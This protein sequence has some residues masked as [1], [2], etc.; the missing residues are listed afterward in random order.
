MVSNPPEDSPRIRAH[1]IYDDPGAAIE[2]LTR[3]FGLRER[4]KKTSAEGNVE[5]AQLEV[6]DSLITI[7]RPS[8][9]GMS[10]RRGVSSMLYIYI[11]DVDQHFARAKAAGAKIV[12]PLDDRPWGDRNYQAEDPEGHQW[13]FAQRVRDGALDESWSKPGQS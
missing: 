3:S 1:L 5:R 11:D 2:W 7:G 6:V 10:P 13:T 8:I 12:L 9:H 4:A